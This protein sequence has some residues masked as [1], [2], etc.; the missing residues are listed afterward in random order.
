MTPRLPGTVHIQIIPDLLQR[1]KHISLLVHLLFS[2]GF[3]RQARA[4][5]AATKGLSRAEL[6]HALLLTPRGFCRQAGNRPAVANGVAQTELLRPKLLHTKVKAK[7]LNLMSL[8]GQ[9]HELPLSLA[10][11]LGK[12][13]WWNSGHNLKRIRGPPSKPPERTTIAGS[14]CSKSSQFKPT[15]GPKPWLEGL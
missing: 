8:L 1:L 7:R 10:S 6:L 15:R 4:L 9:Q 13:L 12:C 5:L 3:W 2:P 14:Q 11:G